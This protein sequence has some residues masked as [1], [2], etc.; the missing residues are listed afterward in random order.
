MV[1]QYL[2]GSALSTMEH[3]LKKKN[4]TVVHRTMLEWVEMGRLGLEGK[5]GN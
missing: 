5:S 2:V 4:T 1:G 3:P